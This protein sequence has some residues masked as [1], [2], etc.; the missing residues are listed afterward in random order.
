ML[1]TDK[2]DHTD[3]GIFNGTEMLRVTF[4]RNSNH[5]P[6]F[7]V[8]FVLAALLAVTGVHS[9]AQT[10]GEPVVIGKRIQIHSNVLNETRTLLIATP[11]GYDQESE[12][13]PVLYVLDGENNFVQVV[14]IVQSLAEAD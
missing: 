9:R 14:G 6:C 10:N 3:R 11:A 8:R 2:T 7:L 5:S 12:R 1:T 4:C 13:Y